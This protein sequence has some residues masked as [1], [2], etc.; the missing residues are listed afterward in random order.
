LLLDLQ[1]H[2]IHPYEVS[3][4]PTHRWMQRGMM[5]ND[6]LIPFVGDFPPIYARFKHFAA[7]HTRARGPFQHIPWLKP[8]HRPS[9][10]QQQPN[11]K[12]LKQETLKQ[13][14]NPKQ[15]LHIMKA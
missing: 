9:V 15:Q 12:N 14:P 5:H 10:F 6:A 1:Y 8:V 11:P 2:I 3:F 7:N 4:E 13:T